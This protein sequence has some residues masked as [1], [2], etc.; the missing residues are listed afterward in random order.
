MIPSVLIG[1]IAIASFSPTDMRR[2]FFIPF[3]TSPGSKLFPPTENR[4]INQ[5]FPST[6][7]NRS[8]SSVPSAPDIL[9]MAA[10]RESK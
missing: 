6:I 10:R 1:R 9:N 2:R 7:L 8:V 4:R 3:C 5:R